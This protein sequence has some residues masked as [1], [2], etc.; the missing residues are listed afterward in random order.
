MALTLTLD[1]GAIATNDA[2]TRTEFNP[3]EHYC[4]V[5]KRTGTEA[6]ISWD[7]CGHFTFS[8]ALP[9]ADAARES[10]VCSPLHFGHFEPGTPP[11]GLVYCVWGNNT[12]TPH[13]HP[14][15][16]HG[17]SSVNDAGQRLE[18]LDVVSSSARTLPL[19]LV[20]SKSPVFLVN[21][22]ND[23]AFQS[24]YT[25]IAVPVLVSACEGVGAPDI[26]GTFGVESGS[27]G[28]AVHDDGTDRRYTF[29]YFLVSTPVISEALLHPAHA[30]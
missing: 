6:R 29:D 30:V 5:T 10:V 27:S 14:A 16:F 26:R 12:E 11:V 1:S 17:Y 4:T 20:G 18:M 7:E 15:V 25:I 2:P 24:Y 8:E 3:A 19:R 9:D 28:Q 23:P 22:G 13:D 21:M